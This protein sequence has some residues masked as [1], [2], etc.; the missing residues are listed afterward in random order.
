MHCRTTNVTIHALSS[1]RKH[2]A[3]AFKTLVVHFYTT[4]TV[5]LLLRHTC[6][7]SRVRQTSCHRVLA[8]WVRVT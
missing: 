7:H 1:S 4:Q 6:Q 2:S 8:I 5:F 3:L